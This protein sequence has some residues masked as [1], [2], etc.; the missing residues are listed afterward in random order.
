MERK[1]FAIL[2]REM[3]KQESGFG[4]YFAADDIY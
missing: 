4:T 1:C 2:D 3:F